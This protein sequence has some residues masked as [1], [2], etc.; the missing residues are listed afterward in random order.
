[1]RTAPAHALLQSVPDHQRQAAARALP[2]MS[3][4]QGADWLTVDAAYSDQLAQKASLIESH[5]ADV[6]QCLPEAEGAAVEILEE[7]LTLLRAR[8]DFELVGQNVCRP[9]GLN[10]TLDR[11][12]PLR[13]LSQLIQEDLCILQKRG[14]THRLTAALLCFP[15]SWTLSEKIGRGLPAIHKPVVEYSEDIAR[16]VQ[17]LFDGVRIGH[18]MWRANLLTYVDP[19][20]YQPRSEADPREQD[21]QTGRYER[22]ERQTLWRLPKTGAVI[23]SIHTTVSKL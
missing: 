4:L 1:M 13:T 22:S 5:G 11:S 8:P 19:T 21:L 20:L 2:G 9:D 7:V 18:P 17:R 16:R 3:P 6:L 10:V 15:A 12:A 23:F 14:D